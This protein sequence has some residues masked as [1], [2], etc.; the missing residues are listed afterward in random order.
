MSCDGGE[1]DYTLTWPDSILDP[2]H[3][4]F[5]KAGSNSK[6][7]YVSLVPIDNPCD[8]QD[9]S[10]SSVDSA[11][12]QDMWENPSSLSVIS[13]SAAEQ[14]TFENPPANI[15][16]CETESMNVM[17]SEIFQANSFTKTV[18]LPD[19]P[20]QPPAYAIVT[21]V[22]KNRTLHFQDSWFQKFNWLHY[23]ASVG[24]VLCFHCCK[25]TQRNLMTLANYSESAFIEDGF[26]NWKKSL[27]K[28]ATHE[29]SKC[30]RFALEQI[31]H[32]MKSEPVEALLSTKKAEEQQV[33]QKCLLNPSTSSIE[34][35]V[36]G[37]HVYGCNF[38]ANQYF[39]K[40]F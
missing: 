10:I 39:S 4:G 29:N 32:T 38:A 2:I 27:E 37:G 25:A 20:Y 40:S 19:C 5:I 18:V 9:P 8:F 31:A 26:S 28:F 14:E 30:H 15:T 1:D 12:E 33:A 36:S 11:V 16:E 3:L 34:T 23:D 21:Q 6:N 24:G 13:G 7:H 17:E 35:N 22:L